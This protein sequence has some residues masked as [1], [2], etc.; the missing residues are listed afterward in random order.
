MDLALNNLQWLI[1]NQT[2][3]K[4]L[5]VYIYLSIDLFLYLNIYANIYKYMY[6]HAYKLTYISGL[7][8]Y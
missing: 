6:M 7:C 2:T 3:L 8:R 1:C 5:S 4:S